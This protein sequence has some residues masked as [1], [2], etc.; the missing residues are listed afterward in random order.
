MR[1]ADHILAARGTFNDKAM[2]GSLTSLGKELARAECFELAPE[3]V[4]ACVNVSRSKPSSILSALPYT[5]VPFSK[6]WVEWTPSTGR[7]SENPNRPVPQKIGFLTEAQGDLSHGSMTWAWR[8][9]GNVAGLPLM[10]GPMGSTFDWRQGA[11]VP[12]TF[13]TISEKIAREMSPQQI[14]AIKQA[15]LEWR[16][17]AVIKAAHNWHLSAD[18]AATVLHE[19]PHWKK[20]AQDTV[21]QA[22]AADLANHAFLGLSRHCGNLVMNIS[23]RVQA[24]DMA[25]EVAFALGKSWSDDVLGEM[26]FAQAFFIMLNSKNAVE[27]RREDLAKL[28]RA[29]SKKGRPALQEF[30]MTALRLPSRLMRAGAGV[31]AAAARAARQH[32]VRG[33]FKVRSTGIFWWSPFVRG[34]ASQAVPRVAYAVRSPQ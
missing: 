5:R 18:K 3:V 13:A 34:D 12:G 29:R 28:N 16:P 4:D 20:H 31:E 8:H 26:S 24:G 27:M 21:E 11:D 14:E 32:L 2:G 30:T 25:Q 6:C 17:D 19:I 10:V 33:H 23:R 1:L 7:E 15:G 22:A 9:N